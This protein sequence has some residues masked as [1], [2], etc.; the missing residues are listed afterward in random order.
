MKQEENNTRHGGSRKGS[1]RKPKLSNPTVI[2]FKIENDIKA[3]AKIIFG[4]RLPEMFNAWLNK[5][6]KNAEKINNS[7]P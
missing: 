2:G 6:I 1:G 7:I 3:K 5:E 4:N